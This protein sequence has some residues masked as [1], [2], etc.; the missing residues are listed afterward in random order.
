ML[1]RS[2]EPVYPLRFQVDEVQPQF[3]WQYRII[4]EPEYY[5]LQSMRPNGWF[6]LYRFTLEPRYP[7]D[8]EVANHYTSTHAQSR[9]MQNLIVALPAPDARASLWN[10]TLL[11]Q[12]PGG[13]TET[14]VDNDE[15]ML[16]LLEERFGLRFA[17]GTRFPQSLSAARYFSDS[18]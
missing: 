15:E 3:G 13:T 6:D 17:A 10:R 4:A 2:R 11:M 12:T 16:R 14:P 9:F 1:F 5:T 18:A 8:Y 7:V